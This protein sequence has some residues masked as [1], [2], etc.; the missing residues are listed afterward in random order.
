MLNKLVKVANT[1]DLSGLVKLADRL[2]KVIIKLAEEDEELFEE[3]QKELSAS[4][5]VVQAIDRSIGMPH[6]ENTFLTRNPGEEAEGSVF[7]EPQSAE[8][9]KAAFWEPYPHPDISAPAQGYSGNISGTFGIVKL[10]D[11][12]SDTPVKAVLGHKGETP[13]MTIL[14]DKSNIPSDL[15]DTDFTTI[16]LGPGDNGLI[17]WTFF[18]G[19]PLAPST[20]AP[21]AETEAVEV[22]ADAINIGFEY[23][24]V[25]TF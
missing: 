23:A 15:I 20:T 11:L 10:E 13:F 5:E 8:S 12:D 9:L 25:A 7:N 16:L 2:D 6:F 19:P 18:P 24:K 4:E 21:S 1:L 17:V 3:R 14:V 22:A